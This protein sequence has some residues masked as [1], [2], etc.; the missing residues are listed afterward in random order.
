MIDALAGVLGFYAQVWRWRVLPEIVPCQNEISA[1][2]SRNASILLSLSASMASS[3]VFA[4][5]RIDSKWSGQVTKW[6]GRLL[7]QKVTLTFAT[8]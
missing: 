1:S 8:H 5:S 3:S 4:P 2:L 6:A 7:A